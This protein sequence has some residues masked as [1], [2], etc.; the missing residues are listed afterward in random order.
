M[1]KRLLV[2]EKSLFLFKEH[3]IACIDITPS[4]YIQNSNNHN[5]MLRYFSIL[6]VKWNLIQ[7]KKKKMHISKLNVF[8]LFYL[9]N[10][11]PFY[12]FIVIT[13]STVFLFINFIYSSGLQRSSSWLF[14]TLHGLLIHLKLEWFYVKYNDVFGFSTVVTSHLHFQTSNRLWR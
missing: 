1:F 2:Y 8:F 4:K 10:W 7:K 3:I 14:S 12:F 6:V 9:F 5:I 11:Y 13:V